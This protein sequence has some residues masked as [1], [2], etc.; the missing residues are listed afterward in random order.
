MDSHGPRQHELVHVAHGILRGWIFRLII[1]DQGV[2]D[3]LLERLKRL[4]FMLPDVRHTD[5]VLIE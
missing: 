1:L 3:C 4:S 5:I 2:L